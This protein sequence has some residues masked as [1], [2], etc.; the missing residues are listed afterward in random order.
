ME[1]YVNSKVLDQ[2]SLLVKRSRGL[3]TRMRRGQRPIN[4][5]CKTGEPIA[6]NELNPGSTDIAKPTNQ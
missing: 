3:E 5:H 2:P 6:D 4:D 1:G